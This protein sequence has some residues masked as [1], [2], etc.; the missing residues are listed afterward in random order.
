PEAMA[1]FL[2]S[3][4][5]H[6]RLEAELAGNPGAADQFSIMQTHPR[7]GD[8]IERAIEQAGT[9]GVAD[10]QRRREAYLAQ[11]DGAV[12]G[13]SAEQGFVRGN[14]FLHPRLKFAFDA[15]QGF[16]LQN[17]PAAVMG[18]GPGNARMIFEGGGS[19]S[20]A[21]QGYVRDQ[22]ARGSQLSGLQ[23]LSLG[24]LDAATALAQVDT[25]SGQQLNARIAAVRSPSNQIY[26]FIF[27]AP[28]VTGSLDSRFL[29]SIESFRLLSD[30]EAA[31]L[32]PYRLQLYRVQPG[33]TPA[34]LAERFP[35]DDGFDL[36]RFL[37][38]N[39]LT[40]GA[41]LSSGQSVKLVVE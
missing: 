9:A 20:G 4:Q 30:S 25:S 24:S 37:V 2:G 10:P 32:R 31:A 11:L 6:S 40:Q 28:N 15:P 41:S 39:G 17:T 36:Q 21:M 12:Y 33:D 13:D 26:R 35:F 8:R 18:S 14:S 3:L 34:S 7:T 1:S 22:W 23:P 16:R 19:Y 38:L 27:A 29:D 5:A